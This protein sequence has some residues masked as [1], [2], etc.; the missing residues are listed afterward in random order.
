[1]AGERQPPP[2]GPLLKDV[3]CAGIRKLLRDVPEGDEARRGGRGEG[4][5]DTRLIIHCYD[6]YW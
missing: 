1:M 6:A 3:L 4:Q 5:A 2:A